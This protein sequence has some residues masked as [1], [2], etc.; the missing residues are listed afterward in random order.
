MSPED[1]EQT[2]L[3]VLPNLIG[4]LHHINL[5]V[6]ALVRK[7]AH[8]NTLFATCASR[9]FRSHDDLPNSQQSYLE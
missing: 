5:S 1:A 6:Q 9:S 4:F 3:A 7:P 8:G 2:A